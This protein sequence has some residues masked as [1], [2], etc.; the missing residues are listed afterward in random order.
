MLTRVYADNFRCLVNFE[1]HLGRKQLVFGRNGGGKSSFL[2]F[3]LLLRNLAV[4]GDF[5][6]SIYAHRTRWLSQDEQI[7]ELE[8][9][10][11]GVRYI[12]RVVIEPA[13]APLRQKLR[14]DSLSADGKFLFTFERGT[15]SLYTDEFKLKVSYPAEPQR[16]AFAAVPR[17]P[18]NK[19][20]SRF[21]DWIT[22]LVGFRINPFAM[23]HIAD[24]EDRGP[25]GS[26]TNFAA[27]YR[28]LV[29]ADPLANSQFISTLKDT[30]DGFAQ[31]RFDSYGE[32]GKLLVADFSGREQFSLLF[33]QLSDGQRCLIGLYAI[34]HFL[35][36][37]GYTVLIDE[38][39][40][41]ISIREVQPWLMTLSE[42]LDDGKGQA[43]LV[44]HHP[45]IL[46]SWAAEYGLNFVRE[47]A[48]PV[49][50]KRFAPSSSTMLTPAELV[51]RGWENGE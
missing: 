33:R 27:W 11:D 26:L 18:E 51:A 32:K 8:A 44:S 6:T 48:G 10:L 39:D 19:K 1:L 31:L 4:V 3:V 7:G 47:D 21:K 17:Q 12:Y 14:T 16:S 20:L 9:E 50:V 24:E 43:I 41:F 30:L 45:E 28:Y 34:V 13:E 35:V 38:P 2:D 46:N 22:L 15:V 5:E 23:E 29:Q 42:F 37:K 25:R 49:R 36:A 40:N